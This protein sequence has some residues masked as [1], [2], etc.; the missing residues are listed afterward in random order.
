MSDKMLLRG[1]FDIFVAFIAGAV[2][3][4]HDA[5]D[6]NPADGR[7]RG[8]IDPMILPLILLSETVLMA[9]LERERLL[10]GWFGGICF[11]LVWQMS[12]YFALLFLLLPV[13]RKH[14]RAR[15]VA[16]LWLLPNFLYVFQYPWHRRSAPLVTLRVPEIG[17]KIWLC[18]WLGV[19][20]VLFLGSFV[21]HFRFRRRILRGAEPVT[22]AETLA[23]WKKLQL[24]SGLHK[25]KYKLFTAPEA[26]TPLT[27]GLTR[28]TT[29]VLLPP[30]EYTPEELRL[31][32]THELVHLRRDDISA[33]LFYAFARSIGW[34]LPL[35]WLSLRRSA[36]DLELSCDEAVLLGEDGETRRDYARL[37]LHT[38][39]DERGFTSCLSADAEALKHR[40]N[41][42]LKPGKKHRGFW[43]VSV[44][45]FV[46]LISDGVAAVRFDPKPV[47]ALL[48]G[49]A[50]VRSAALCSDGRIE[51]LDIEA[52]LASGLWEEILNLESERLSGDYELRGEMRL[53][54]VVEADGKVGSV[55][56]S[57][58]GVAVNPTLREDGESRWTSGGAGILAKAREIEI[59]R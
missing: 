17:L 32:L 25:P 34:F 16:S 52:F 49:E 44:F 28:A 47:S 56:V 24:D 26:R 21:R 43:L 15:T 14:F 7:W 54:A 39:G 20:A 58:C 1:V 27:V 37:L 45:L 35:M 12:V 10:T 42:I 46:L 33:K 6:E 38:A 41:G 19:A 22:D 23:L 51:S 8:W 11:N 2:L 55:V 5:E 48:D 36:E 59:E 57:E 13:L 4:L 29:R 31:I 3:W 40:L 30:A 53:V 50:T 9:F 18:V